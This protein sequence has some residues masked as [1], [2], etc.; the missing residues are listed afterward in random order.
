MSGGGFILGGL[1]QGVGG[2]LVKQGESDILARREMALSRLRGEQAEAAAT[3]DE[4][5]AVAKDDRALKNGIVLEG[6]KAKGLLAVNRGKAIDTATIETPAKTASE[7]AINE[8]KSQADQ[9]KD[10]YIENLKS[11]N[12]T[13][14]KRELAQMQGTEV[15]DSYT[16]PST[17]NLVLIKK[18]GGVFRTT[19][20][21]APPKSTD[22]DPIGDRLGTPPTA[23][24]VAAPPVAAAT[25]APAAVGKTVTMADLAEAQA[26][27]RADPRNKGLSAPE[28]NAKVQARLREAGYTIGR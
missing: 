2:A 5:A 3:R 17:G 6:A 8:R 12:D 14:S 4:A 11:R 15:T 20:K 27:A 10:A 21:G 23:P 19:F 25:P 1:L 18:N 26:R 9:A 22:G 28:I 24:A 7:I 16:D 13:A